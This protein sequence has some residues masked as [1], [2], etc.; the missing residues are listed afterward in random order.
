MNLKNLIVLKRWLV[1]IKRYFW[2]PRVLDVYT[3]LYMDRCIIT[4]PCVLYRDLLYLYVDQTLH[5]IIWNKLSSDQNFCFQ[6]SCWET[7]TV[8]IKIRKKISGILF[9]LILHSSYCLPPTQIPY[10][11]LCV[12]IG[13][14]YTCICSQ[15]LKKK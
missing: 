2:I 5:W 8:F 4:A 11:K 14:V 15:D 12:Y 1:N 6:S 9:K 7:K 3:D 10:I 13:A